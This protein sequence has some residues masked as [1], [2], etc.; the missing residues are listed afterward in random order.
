MAEYLIDRAAVRKLALHLSQ[1]RRAGKFKRVGSTFY[2]R[3]EARLKGVI[4]IMVHAQPAGGQTIQASE[5]APAQVEYPTGAPLEVKERLFDDEG[6]IG[7]RNYAL[8]ASL[9]RKHGG[10]SRVSHDFYSLVNTRLYGLVG[11]EVFKH[12]SV[13][14]TLL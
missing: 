10:F 2:D 1:T 14:Q 8:H 7:I 9:S 12:P 4:Y 11:E 6:L 5:P 13:G 3:L